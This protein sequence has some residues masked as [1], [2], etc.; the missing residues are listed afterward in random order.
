MSNSEQKP[1][2]EAEVDTNNLYREE[3]Y[4]DLKVA[5]V[6]RL[7]PVKANGSQDT[8]REVLYFGQT[9]ILTPQGAIPVQGPIEAKSLKEA[10]ERFPQAMNRAVERMV[11][12]IEDLRRREAGRIVVPGQEARSKLHL[13]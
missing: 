11:S 6:R 7:I 1:T 10:L 2:I 4:S 9:T 5:T 13:G 8:G 3:V 12:E